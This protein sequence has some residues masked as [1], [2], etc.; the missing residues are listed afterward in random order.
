[1]ILDTKQDTN[2]GAYEM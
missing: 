2:I 1:L